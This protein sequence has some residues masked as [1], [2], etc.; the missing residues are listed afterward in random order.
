M[1]EEKVKVSLRAVTAGISSGVTRCIGDAGYN[2]EL[3]SIQEMYSLNKTQ[4]KELFRHPQ[5]KGLRVRVAVE[6]AFEIVDDL[7]EEESSTMNAP[8]YGEPT[9]TMISSGT[10]SPGLISAPSEEE[11]SLHA[12]DSVIS[13][14]PQIV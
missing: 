6:P 12:E 5:L 8:S 11:Q 4:V 1:N 2:A 13:P 7:T 14:P 3:G 10:L 9:A